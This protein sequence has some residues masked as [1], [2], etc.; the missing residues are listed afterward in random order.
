MPTYDYKCENCGHTFESFQSIKA[1]PLKK[2]PECG[3]DTLKRLIGTGAGLIFKGSGFY[4]TDYK[5]Q[6]KSSSSKSNENSSTSATAE[7]K[8]DTSSKSD[9][10]NSQTTPEKA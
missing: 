7:K 9:S 8:S 10:K 2:C 3:K 6:G 4:L 5:N 1:D